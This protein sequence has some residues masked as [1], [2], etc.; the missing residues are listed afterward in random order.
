MQPTAQ[1]DRFRVT[2]FVVSVT[3]AVACPAVVV[4][5]VKSAVEDLCVVH[6]ALAVVLHAAC[7]INPVVAQ[8]VAR[9]DKPAVEH[10]V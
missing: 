7:S 8:N 1:W 10:S 3:S 2:A 5:Q 6:R 9:L 4:R